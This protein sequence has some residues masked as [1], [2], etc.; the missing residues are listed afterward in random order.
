M[1]ADSGDV[2]HLTLEQEFRRNPSH[3]FLHARLGYIVEAGGA[4]AADGAERERRLSTQF[5]PCPLAGP[6]P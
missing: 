4:A 2:S 3:R 1:C 6:F 5:G